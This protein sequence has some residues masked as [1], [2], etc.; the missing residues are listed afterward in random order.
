MLSEHLQIRQSCFETTGEIAARLLAGD[1]PAAVWQSVAAKA[2][3]LIG[4]DNAFIAVPEDRDAPDNEVHELIVSAIADPRSRRFANPERLR[5]DDSSPGQVF[6]TREPLRLNQFDVNPGPGEPSRSGP[7]LVLPLR[8]LGRVT[9]VLVV[10]RDEGRAPFSAEEQSLAAAFADQA[11][12]TVELG[13]TQRRRR[14]LDVLSDRDRIARALHDRVIKQL[15]EIGILLQGTLQIVHVPV[16]RARLLDI[17]DLLQ[18][19]INGFQTA[20]FDL[21][22]R[23]RGR[24]QELIVDEMLLDP[25]PSGQAGENWNEP[26]NDTEDEQD[27]C[28]RPQLR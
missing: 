3:A 6:R 2:S 24:G 9:G 14:E 22:H 13:D 1:D 8:A 4:A 5:I 16:V 7:A 11:A 17:V 27:D 19:T 26:L 23:T 15:F 20:I 12:V 18:I 28:A 25:A 21:H 10:A